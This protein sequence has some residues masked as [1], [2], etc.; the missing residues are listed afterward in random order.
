V[1]VE[2]PNLDARAGLSKSALQDFDICQ[3]RAWFS[4]HHPMPW[5]PNPDASFG[6]CVDR[7]LEVLIE[8][9]RAGIP[10]DFERALQAAREQEDREVEV[11]QDEVEVAIRAFADD[12]LQPTAKKGEERQRA[13]LNEH[14]WAYCRTQAHIHVPIWDLGEVDGH[15]D[16]ILASNEIFDVKTAKRS[17]DTAKTL[18]LILYGV[19][20]EE[21]SGKVV[22]EVGYLVW[23][24]L[25][26]GGRWQTITTFLTDDL[27]GW[28]YERVSAYIRAV[29][30]DAVLNKGRDPINFTFPGGT[31]NGRFC[32]GCR[33]NPLYGGPCRMAVAEDE[34]E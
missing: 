26:R 13:P 7:G 4:L 18:E 10:L 11:D 2:R 34:D 31:I 20:V 1:I 5:I 23:V 28:A 6:S 14:D 22:P 27:R 21:E 17:R 19:M 24:R 33:F 16:I 32:R 3:Q 25:K 30:A 8:C 9:A 12:D 15:P 29:K